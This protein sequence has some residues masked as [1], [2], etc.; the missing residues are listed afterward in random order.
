MIRSAYKPSSSVIA[1]IIGI[2]TLLFGA[3]G[4]FVDLQEA[5][6]TI[7][8]A[9][10]KSGHSG[11]IG[12]IK[13]RFLSFG[14]I[15][16]IAFLLLV[17]LVVSA[18]LSAL[19]KFLSDL[20]PGF[21]HILQVVNFIISFGFITVL[22]AMIYKLLP[23][24]KIAWSDVWIGAAVTSLLFTIGKFLIG[25]YLGRSSIASPYGA[26]GSLVIILVWVYYSA[27]ILFFGAEFTQIYANKYGS[28]SH[29]RRDAG[30]VTK[31]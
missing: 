8:S 9:T 22:F 1:T 27:Q 15:L 20:L 2:A 23:D 26:A 12:M 6:N 3:T 29:A 7:W 5:L 25:L 13:E 31:S 16:G 24:I 30:S 18:G 10:S 11:I 14:M 28:L 4:A 17:S 21:T 19:G